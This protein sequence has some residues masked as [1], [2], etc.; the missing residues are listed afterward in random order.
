MNSKR[1]LFNSALGIFSFTFLVIST[2]SFITGELVYAIKEGGNTVYIAIFFIALVLASSIFML[3]MLLKSERKF[4]L[5]IL[6]GLPV[7]IF[8]VIRFFDIFGSPMDYLLEFI[9]L[10]VSTAFMVFFLITTVFIT[11]EETLKSK[12]KKREELVSTALESQDRYREALEKKK[13]KWEEVIE[14]E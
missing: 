14:E 8:C 9:T 10:L 2:I 1:Q 6:F 13:E 3:I 12:E 5:Y 11:N 7:L 4:F